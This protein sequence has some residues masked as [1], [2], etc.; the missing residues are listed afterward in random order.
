[1]LKIYITLKKI[2]IKISINIDEQNNISDFLS[3]FDDKIQ[4]EEYKLNNLETYKQGLLQQMF[5]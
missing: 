3:K 1:M 4:Q 5:I 2:K